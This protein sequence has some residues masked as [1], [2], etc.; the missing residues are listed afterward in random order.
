M[1]AQGEKDVVAFVVVVAHA[2]VC[3]C[4]GQLWQ[5]DNKFYCNGKYMS[6]PSIQP[7][8]LIGV[9][10][11]VVSVVFAA[12]TCVFQRRVLFLGRAVV[13]ESFTVVSAFAAH[14]IWMGKLT[15]PC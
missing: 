8:V 10:I 5:G 3:C 4:R 6:G 12:T 9:V 7:A 2:S 1:Q 11:F 14:R 13:V 15:H